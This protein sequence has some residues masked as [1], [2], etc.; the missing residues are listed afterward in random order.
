[1]LGQEG[2][3][4]TNVERTAFQQREWMGYIWLLSLSFEIIEVEDMS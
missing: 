2:L 4:E 3:A 1:M